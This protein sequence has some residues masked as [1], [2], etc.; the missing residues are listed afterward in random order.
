MLQDLQ[1]DLIESN[2]KV[3]ELQGEVIEFYSEVIENQRKLIEDQKRMIS[4]LES[5][6]EVEKL[7]KTTPT[8][9]Q[10]SWPQNPWELY[11]PVR[12][13]T[14]LPEETDTIS[15]IPIEPNAKL[16]DLEFTVGKGPANLSLAKN[17]QEKKA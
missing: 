1:K 2:K 16:S 11:G 6:L 7:K 13:G 15:S 14:P 5:K 9:P 3:I 4:N 8:F 10:P 17:E 12:Y